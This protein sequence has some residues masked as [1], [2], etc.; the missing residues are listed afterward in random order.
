MAAIRLEIVDPGQVQAI[1]KE[2]VQERM[3]IE[4]QR[5]LLLE[6]IVQVMQVRFP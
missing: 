1:Q 6:I 2:F 3:I 4:V 5:K